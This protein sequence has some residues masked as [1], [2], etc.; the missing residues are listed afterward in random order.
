MK[1][2]LFPHK[3]SGLWYKTDNYR[4]LRVWY[5]ERGLKK[6]GNHFRR[7]ILKFKKYD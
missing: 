1:H 3:T 7:L 2:K 4:M 5:I 6:K